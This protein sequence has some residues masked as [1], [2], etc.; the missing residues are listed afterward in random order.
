MLHL[1]SARSHVMSKQKRVSQPCA[2]LRRRRTGRTTHNSCLGGRGRPPQRARARCQPAFCVFFSFFP[3]DFSMHDQLLR[4]FGRPGQEKGTR[5]PPAQAVRTQPPRA[6]VSLPQPIRQTCGKSRYKDS[7]QRRYDWQNIWHSANKMRQSGWAASS[8]SGQT[9]LQR[10]PHRRIIRRPRFRRLIIHIGGPNKGWSPRALPT[11]LLGGPRHLLLE[12]LRQRG[13]GRGSA[14]PLHRQDTCT[15]QSTRSFSNMLGRRH[16]QTH[17]RGR[18]AGACTGAS[19]RAAGHM[20]ARAVVIPA[21]VADPVARDGG[22]V[23]VQV[24]GHLRRLLTVGRVARGADGPGAI[25]LL[26]LPLGALLG[27]LSPDLL[28]DGLRLPPTRPRP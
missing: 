4:R 27:R 25:P 24:R 7:Q 23:A 26:P 22:A 19:R 14:G 13:E 3:L 20:P 8:S 11:R 16:P 15:R 21:P 9:L 5:P 10:R 18:R 6:I 17:L 2:S 12:P 1:L 28:V